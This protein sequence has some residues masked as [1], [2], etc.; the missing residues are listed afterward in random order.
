MGYTSDL[1]FTDYGLFYLMKDVIG[2]R[3]VDSYFNP[4]DNLMNTVNASDTAA[5]ITAINEVFE[6]SA[7]PKPFVL[8]MINGYTE[9]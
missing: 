7:E 3:K 4:T 2:A 8:G 9:W 6:S 5:G 1:A